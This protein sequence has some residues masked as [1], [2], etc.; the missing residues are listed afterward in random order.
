M[1]TFDQL[2]PNDY[3]YR[4]IRMETAVQVHKIETNPMTGDK[5]FFYWTFD[6]IMGIQR[7]DQLL[8]PKPYLGQ[9]QFY[10]SRYG[11]YYPCR[12][13][14]ITLKMNYLQC[15]IDRI[16]QAIYEKQK[17]ASTIQKQIDELRYLLNSLSR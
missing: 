12:E 13:A 9:N 6:K 2:V 10:R 1:K 11:M 5:T 8:I 3:I 7:E 4:D 15:D 14:A 17:E 16:N